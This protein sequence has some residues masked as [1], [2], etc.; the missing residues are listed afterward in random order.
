MKK[1]TIRL[2]MIL[3]LLTVNKTFCWLL[4][5]TNGIQE[6][7]V[8]VMIDWWNE[9]PCSD[10]KFVLP[11]GKNIKINFASHCNPK[12]INAYYKGEPPYHHGHTGVR[13]DKGQH[14]FG[15]FRIVKQGPRFTM[16]GNSVGNLEGAPQVGTFGQRTPQ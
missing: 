5:I 12:A 16:V 2:A 14:P 10:K 11:P 1:L 6:D 7:T 4:D 3:S 8:T 9:Q 15:G 13:F